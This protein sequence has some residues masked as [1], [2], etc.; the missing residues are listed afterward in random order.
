VG[1]KEHLRAGMNEQ[2]V[3]HQR[4]RAVERKGHNAASVGRD[5]SYLYELSVTPTCPPSKQLYIRPGVISPDWDWAWI[6]DRSY[7]EAVTCDFADTEQT[8]MD[9]SFNNA[10]YYLPVLLCYYGDWAAYHNLESYDDPQVFDNIV[11]DEVAT[12]G[13]A[14]SV[15]DGYLNGMTTIYYKVP[16]VALMLR[17]NGVTGVDG[18]ILPIDQVNRGRSYLYRDIRDRMSLVR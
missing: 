12:A 7:I 3:L 9:A 6:M 1:G 18:Q 5:Q 16:L 2:A 10:G 4:L 14:E 13:E 8:G 15:I 17:N 11:G